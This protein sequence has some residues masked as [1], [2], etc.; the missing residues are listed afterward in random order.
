MHDRIDAAVPTESKA[1]VAERALDD[2]VR[3]K[4][5][6][7]AF[8]TMEIDTPLGQL[9]LCGSLCVKANKTGT[10]MRGIAAEMSVVIDD[11][12][13]EISAPGFTGDRAAR[14]NT[15]QLWQTALDNVELFIASGVKSGYIE[16]VDE[17][18]RAVYRVAG[19]ILWS[20]CAIAV[21]RVLRNWS[22]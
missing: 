2:V 17:K 22:L 20:C 11:L 7:K 1:P 15:L 19:V 21:V 3:Y 6:L 14:R 8:R 16:I 5:T 12:R 9:M 18:M 10:T 4:G 13:A